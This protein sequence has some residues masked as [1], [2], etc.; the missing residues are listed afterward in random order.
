MNCLES[1]GCHRATYRFTF[2]FVHVFPKTLPFLPLPA[3]SHKSPVLHHAFQQAHRLWI[4]IVRTGL[5][6]WRLVVHVGKHTRMLFH[7]NFMQLQ[8]SSSNYPFTWWFGKPISNHVQKF[9]QEVSPIS[10]SP[11]WA[12]DSMVPPHLKASE[13]GTSPTTPVRWEVDTPS[14][15]GT[16][17]PETR[18][19]NHLAPSVG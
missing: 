5:V 1:W 15:P 2:V 9:K 6:Q 17:D 8:K 11:R 3:G 7:C 10:S 19:N 12:S 14:D 13:K 16:L 18:N 4:A